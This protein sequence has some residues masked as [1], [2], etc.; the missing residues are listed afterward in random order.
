MYAPLSTKSHISFCECL[1]QRAMALKGLSSV[2]CHVLL[3]WIHVCAFDI[4][5][6]SQLSRSW[7]SHQRTKINLYVECVWGVQRQEYCFLASNLLLFRFSSTIALFLFL[8][9]GGGGG[10]KQVFVIDPRQPSCPPISSAITINI[11]NVNDNPPSFAF[12]KQLHWVLLYLLGT[13]TEKYRVE[14]LPFSV[15]RKQKE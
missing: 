14:D 13:R 10:A 3:L 12:S 6:C 2:T 5:Q 11:T 1:S 15:V 7:L 8:W 4:C 9:G